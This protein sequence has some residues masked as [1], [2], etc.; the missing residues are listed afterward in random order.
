MMTATKPLLSLTAADLMSPKVVTIPQDMSLQGAA[1]LLAQADVSGAPVV[2]AAGR[3]V[4]V[5]SARDFVGWADHRT[6]ASQPEASAPAGFCSAW[7]M[8]EGDSVPRD[9]VHNYMTADTV[10]VAPGTPIGSLARMM[11]DARIHRLV[12]LDRMDRPVG[13]VSSTDVLAAVA[14]AARAHAADA[15]HFA[16]ADEEAYHDPLHTRSP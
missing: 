3:C 15:D 9:V 12:V 5:I 11:L 2:D 1:H 7:Q 6:R 13:V 4:G 16:A 14:R 10:T 8:M